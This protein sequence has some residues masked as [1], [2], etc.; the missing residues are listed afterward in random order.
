MPN[1]L[2]R[3]DLMSLET[4]AIERT[5]FRARVIAHR[6][7]RTLTL[8]PHMTLI[9]EDRLTV[10][11]QIQEMLRIERVFEPDAIQRELDVYNPLIPDGRNLKATLL[12]EYSDANVRQSEL[13][14]LRGIE[15]RVAAEVSGRVPVFAIADEDLDRSNAHKTAAVH[16]LRFEFDSAAIAA[17][18]A[19]ATLA[20]AVD[21]TRYPYRALLEAATCAALLRDFA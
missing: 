4:Y 1:R 17:L 21:D 10:Q 15:H 16:F 14:R 6:K 18:R 9:F 3:S 12:I 19:G 2:L 5:A 8:G 20:F 13:E 7:P 11:Y